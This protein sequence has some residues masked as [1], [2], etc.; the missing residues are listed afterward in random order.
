M[1]SV[2]NGMDPPDRSTWRWHQQSGFDFD[3]KRSPV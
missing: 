2:V 1:G 3:K